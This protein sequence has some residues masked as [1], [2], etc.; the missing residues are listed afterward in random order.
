M[1]RN[2]FDVIGNV[3]T[4]VSAL[5]G[6]SHQTTI[7]DLMEKG[8]VT[9]KIILK[10]DIKAHSSLHSVFQIGNGSLENTRG[11]FD[12][13]INP[14][15]Q[16]YKLKAGSETNDNKLLVLKT[17]PCFKTVNPLFKMVEIS[18]AK[19]CNDIVDTPIFIDLWDHRTNGNHK[20]L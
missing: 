13:T 10:V 18:N 19:L 4:T 3:Q 11:M 15:L 8:K 5:F 2:G 14:F 1:D 17:E 12:G 7:L 6:A 16:F 9:G 20:L